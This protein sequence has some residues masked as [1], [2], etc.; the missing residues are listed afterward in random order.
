VGTGPSRESSSLPWQVSLPPRSWNVANWEP[1]SEW[2]GSTAVEVRT[3]V[4]E[5]GPVPLRCGQMRHGY[6]PH[7]RVVVL[8]R[9]R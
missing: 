3:I 1:E 5:G 4:V 9:N 7:Y 8:R 6:G 2:E